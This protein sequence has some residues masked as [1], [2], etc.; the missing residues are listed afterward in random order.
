M[1]RKFNK[2]DSEEKVFREFSA[3][4]AKITR[5]AVIAGITSG[6]AIVLLYQDI[7]SNATA[8]ILLVTIFLS[9][10][11]ANVKL[12]RCPACNSHLGKLYLGLK[13]PKYCPDCGIKL[14]K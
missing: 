9:A 11:F 5:L 1:A 2:P 10:A 7:I 6:A 4:R 14:V 3:R 8:A 13:G 12:W